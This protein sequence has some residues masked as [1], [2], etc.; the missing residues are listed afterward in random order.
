MVENALNSELSTAQRKPALLVD[1]LI[2]P[3]TLFHRNIPK[4]K[5]SD[6]VAALL[7][8][9]LFE[10]PY[11]VLSDIEVPVTKFRE[12]NELE[13]LLPELFDSLTDNVW[14]NG[15]N[16]ER[17]ERLEQAWTT[18]DAFVQERDQTKQKPSEQIANT[19]VGAAFQ[20]EHLKP[21]S[22]WNDDK[23]Q[24]GTALLVSDIHY[25]LRAQL[26]NIEAD[27]GVKGVRETFHAALSAFTDPFVDPAANETN[28]FDPEFAYEVKTWVGGIPK[29]LVEDD[30]GKLSRQICEG[31]EHVISGSIDEY[32]TFRGQVKA[33]GEWR[34]LGSDYVITA[35]KDYK[36]PRG[37][38]TFVGP[39]SIF[40]STYER[41]R[42]NS[43]HTDDEHAKLDRLADT[44]SGFMI[45]RNGLR[46]LPYGR[47]DSDFFEIEKRRSIRAFS[48]RSDSTGI[49]IAALM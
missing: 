41:T 49:P 30:H 17:S 4:R 5:S 23:V 2:P 9:R 42:L 15:G 22:V 27:G 1:G 6:F 34:A 14:G 26:P 37:P 43:T 19:I 29:P 10:N 48:A 32:G 8:W 46:V 45:F 11:L 44:R 16:P 36:P 21:W 13:G 47:E 12:R 18:Y 28:A 40:V 20:L 39:F 24:S 35:P 3:K 7:D 31:M 38:N 33:F 25:D